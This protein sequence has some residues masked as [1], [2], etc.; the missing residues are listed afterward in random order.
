MPKPAGKKYQAVRFRRQFDERRPRGLRA[1]RGTLR[2]SVESKLAAAETVRCRGEIIDAG[3]NTHSLLS[4]LGIDVFADVAAIRISSDDEL[5]RLDRR[6]D[7]VESFERRSRNGPH[8]SL[9]RVAERAEIIEVGA[10]PHF[11]I[12]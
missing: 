11:W 3:Q 10:D 9:D 7:Q 12:D 6:L 1:G 8:E 2:K 5:P 4:S